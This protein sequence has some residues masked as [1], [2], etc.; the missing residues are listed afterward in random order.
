MQRYTWWTNVSSWYKYG[1]WEILLPLL[2]WCT[3]RALIFTE[4]R[5]IYVHMVTVVLQWWTVSLLFLFFRFWSRCC[6]KCE[7]MGAAMIWLCLTLR[8]QR[9]TKVHSL[10]SFF[11][12]TVDLIS[13]VSFLHFKSMYLTIFQKLVSPPNKTAIV[14]INLPTSINDPRTTRFTKQPNNLSLSQLHI[15]QWKYSLEI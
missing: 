2:Q 12:Q 11:C 14:V 7:L 9:N 10:N 15:L 13:K 4:H 5:I 6:L 3:S 8:E 1:H